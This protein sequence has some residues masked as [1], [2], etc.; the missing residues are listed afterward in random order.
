M[1]TKNFKETVAKVVKNAIEEL[2]NNRKKD[3]EIYDNLIKALNWNEKEEDLPTEMG[4]YFDQA[5]KDA[6]YDNT[7]TFEVE[8]T[9][10][11]DGYQ[12]GA[13]DCEVSM[14]ECCIYSDGMLYYD[15][16]WND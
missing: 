10:Y 15:D 6:L 12:R 3:I 1:E 9:Y 8:Y 7:I 16:R 5:V 2:K 13:R 11:N 14:N 4:D